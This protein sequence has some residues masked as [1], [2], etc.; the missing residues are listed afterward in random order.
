MKKFFLRIFLPFIFFSAFGMMAKATVATDHFIS[1]SSGEWLN[2]ANWLSSP[3]PNNVAYVPADLAPDFQA[4]TV[5]IRNGHNITLT[6]ERL[7]DQLT[8][9]SGG[10]LQVAPGISLTLNNGAG[11]DM[12]VASGGSLILKSDAAKTARFAAL[13]PSATIS[14]NN[15]VTIERYFPANR[16]NRLVTAPLRSGSGTNTTVFQTWQN[17]GGAYTP[18][19]G[20]LVTGPIVP[21][22]TNGIDATTPGYSLFTFNGTAFNGVPNTKSTSSPL[23]TTAAGAANRSFLIFVR[24][25]RSL[26][27]LDANDSSVTVLKATG[28]LQTGPQ[29]FNFNIGSGN[30]TI[31]GNPYASPVNF[32]NVVKTGFRNRFFGIDPNLGSEGAYVL[33]DDT[34]ETG[35][36]TVTPNDPDPLA[37]TALDQNIQ[38][39]QAVLIQATQNGSV[40][41][42]FNETDKNAQGSNLVFRENEKNPLQL[43][44]VNLMIFKGGR[45]KL[46]DGTSVLFSDKFSKEVIEDEDAVKME[47]LGENLAISRGGKFLM[48]EKR[49]EVVSTDTL[50]LKFWNLK[51]NAYQLKFIPLNLE[52]A[53]FTAF[54]EDAYL[55]TSIPLDLTSP[56][57]LDFNLTDDQASAN[58]NRF[59][60][61]FKANQVLPLKFS[62][63]KAY[64]K[65][66]QVQVEWIMGEESNIRTYEIEKS[67]DGRTFKKS[68]EVVPRVLINQNI[69]YSW[70]DM[71]PL[72]GD[73]LYRIKAIEKSGAIRYS[74]IVNVRIGKGNSGINIY[75][76][77]I[78]NKVLSLQFNNQDKGTYTVKLLNTAGQEVYVGR[79]NHLGGSSTQ[80]LQLNNNLSKGSYQLQIASD[81]SNFAQKVMIQ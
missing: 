48:L 51:K 4:N 14:Q 67:I 66:Q 8:I 17:N 45:S 2:A 23:F 49:S 31:V 11:V 36:Y 57:T 10:T 12:N 44:G 54:L 20:T 42:T 55:K 34:N 26:T 78:I 56:V 15:N 69:A 74:Q 19:V 9:A 21:T 30:R 40:S 60:I 53:N 37:T 25:D 63:V 46:A 76:N 16:A 43:L 6:D 65:S 38:S 79:I 1:A 47:N 29:T 5:T 61:I 3:D 7:L 28:N 33:V 68:G 64:Q 81:K 71:S 70:V 75:P 77:P 80:T 22:G 13:P 41:L 52:T 50:F 35:T 27:T 39:C 72:K 24:G 73:N 59:M 18:G 32:A 62:N 58:S